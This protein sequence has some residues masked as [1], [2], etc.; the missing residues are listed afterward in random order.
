MEEQLD[1][2]I[3]HES[4]YDYNKINNIRESIET[5]SKFNQIEILK[6]ITRH[7]E[8]IINENKNGIHINLS[9]F[10]DNILDE[11]LL[12][13]NYVTQQENDLNNIEKQKET[14][15]NTYFVKDN[16]DNCSANISKKYVT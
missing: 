6:I 3:K 2:E 4:K 13:I 11:L 14:Y 12:Y 1:Y 8:V 15:K 7:K 9:D 5:M 16:K 10:S